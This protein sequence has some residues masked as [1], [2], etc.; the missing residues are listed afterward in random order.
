MTLGEQFEDSTVDMIRDAF[1]QKIRPRGDVTPPPDHEDFM[2]L[3]ASG[4][5]A[6]KRALER[7]RKK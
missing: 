4:A 3:R 6:R 7:R 2:W 1:F 5:D